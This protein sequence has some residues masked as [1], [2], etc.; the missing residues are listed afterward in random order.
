MTLVAP[1]LR[2]VL[3]AALLVVFV[4]A[5]ADEEQGGLEGAS[6]G[7]DAVV[8]GE[9]DRIELFYDDIVVDADVSVIDPDGTEV[10]VETRVDTDISVIAELGASLSEPGVHEVRHGVDAVDGDRVDGSYTFTFDPSAPAPQLVFPPEDSGVPWLLWL[11]AVVGV[12]V[13]AVLGWQLLQSLATSR[14]A[15]QSRQL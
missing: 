6:P 8:G 12:V 4:G 15:S 5:C 2:G 7:P 3:A 11:V 14:R 9:I 13:I 1:R 10:S